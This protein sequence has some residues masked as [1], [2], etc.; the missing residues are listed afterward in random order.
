VVID[1]YSG[2]YKSI[3]NDNITFK[4]KH[5]KSVSK[6][7]Q[8]F[9]L[10]LLN[11]RVSKRLSS[12]QAAA[13]PWVTTHSSL[14]KSDTKTVFFMI[15]SQRSGS[16]WLRTLIDEREDIAAPHPP[17]I[18]RD[19]M[20]IIGKFGDLSND[21]NF[22]VLVDHVCILVERNQVQ[23]N[24]LHGSKISFPRLII[25]NKAIAS[26][27]RLER[28]GVVIDSTYYLLSIF[29][30]IM[31]HYAESQGKRYWMC[32]SMGMS[33]YHNHLLHFYGDKRLRYVYLVRDPRDVVLSFMNT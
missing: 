4:S 33:M 25:Y 24:D 15:G 32:K 1:D 22:R 9:I 7:A 12:E 19:F 26:L 27:K 16:N 5:W 31:T 11:K 2:L 8:S 20:P 29:D 3:M 6:D 18:M 30:A 10:S 21:N 28:E 14:V 17:H 13:N 23:W